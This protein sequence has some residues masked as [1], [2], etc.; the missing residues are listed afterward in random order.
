MVLA[1]FLSL[2]SSIN[3]SAMVLFLIS[4]LLTYIIT[5]LNISLKVLS[6]RPIS[7]WD[8][9]ISYVNFLKA[10]LPHGTPLIVMK[11][12][13]TAP[14]RQKTITGGRSL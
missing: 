6:L 9:A 11:A 4:T 7:I 13:K 12:V 2:W 3:T 8:D 14:A 1:I 5:P 10:S